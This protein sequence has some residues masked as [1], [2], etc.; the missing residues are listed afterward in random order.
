[1]RCG[2]DLVF[3]DYPKNNN[4]IN[5]SRQDILRL[6]IKEFFNLSKAKNKFISSVFIQS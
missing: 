1:M 4:S 2:I 6:F 5:V 3:H